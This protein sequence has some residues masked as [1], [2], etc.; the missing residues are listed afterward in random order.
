VGGF[1]GERG[2]EAVTDTEKKAKELT[3]L[4]SEV[5]QVTAGLWSGMGGEN[6]QQKSTA[7][8]HAEDGLNRPANRELPRQPRGQG[9]RG[10]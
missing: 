10:A 6:G 1:A 9:S 4:E 8:N 5:D 7:E 2:V 3:G